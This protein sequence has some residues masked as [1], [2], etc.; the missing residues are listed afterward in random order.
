[1]GSNPIPSANLPWSCENNSSGSEK[2]CLAGKCTHD[3]G[4]FVGRRRLPSFSGLLAESAAKKQKDDE[5]DCENADDADAAAAV[6]AAAMTI[7]TA[8][9]EEQYDD[10]NDEDEFHGILPSVVGEGCRYPV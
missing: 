7:V 10:K 8:A 2:L 3:L 6:I 9:A 5:D 4:A 1:V